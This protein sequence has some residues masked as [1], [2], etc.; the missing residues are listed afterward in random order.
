MKAIGLHQSNNN[1]YEQVAQLLL[2]MSRSYGVVWNIR[3][4][5][6]KFWQFALLF[7]VCFNV[8]YSLDS[9]SVYGSRGC[10]VAVWGDRV[11]GVG[12]WK[13]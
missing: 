12:S 8:G 6:W 4:T 7:T 10:T 5:F 1:K 11:I 9:T 13:L 2:R 3:A